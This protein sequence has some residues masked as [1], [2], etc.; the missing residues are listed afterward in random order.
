MTFGEAVCKRRRELGLSQEKFAEIVN[1]HYATIS[2][3]ETNHLTPRSK[4]A[5]KIAKMLQ[6]DGLYA[7]G[8]ID[9]DLDVLEIQTIKTMRKLE[10]VLDVIQSLKG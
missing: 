5:K 10:T 8:D 9:V 2:K 4:S 7:S 6:L 1:V 3:V